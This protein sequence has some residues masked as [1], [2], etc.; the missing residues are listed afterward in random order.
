MLQIHIL[1]KCDCIL[2]NNFWR[3]QHELNYLPNRVVTT[4]FVSIQEEFWAIATWPKLVRKLEEYFGIDSHIKLVHSKDL[5]LLLHHWINFQGQVSSV[6]F[7]AKGKRKYR[8]ITYHWTYITYWQRRME[9]DEII[10]KDTKTDGDNDI[11]SSEHQAILC[12]DSHTCWGMAYF[13][14]YLRWVCSSRVGS[15]SQPD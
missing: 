6:G 3:K 9:F 4:L 1:I 11:V 13:S 2:K 10:L 8:V 5:P 15:S 12:L 14:H 7:V